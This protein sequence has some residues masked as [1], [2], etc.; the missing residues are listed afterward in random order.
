MVLP[1]CVPEL[2]DGQRRG[3]QRVVT[4]LSYDIRIYNVYFAMRWNITFKKIKK[5]S[6]IPDGSM[7]TWK[8][9]MAIFCKIVYVVTDPY[10]H[11]LLE[12]I[13]N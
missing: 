4:Y 11:R 3:D 13:T 2:L 8:F 10:L 1:P 5:A 12:S 6:K 9:R 7:F